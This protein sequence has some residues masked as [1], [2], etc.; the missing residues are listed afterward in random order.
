[1]H[2]S[3]RLRP[4]PFRPS[5]VL[6]LGR[7][8]PLRAALGSDGL[9]R[10]ADLAELDGVH[11]PVAPE[12]G[13]PVRGQTLPS[14]LELDF[15]PLDTSR[16]L[17]LALS[18]WIEFGTASTMIALSQTSDITVQWPALEARGG[19]G[20]WHP[21]DTTVGLLGGKRR[22]VTVELDGLLPR[23]ADRLRLSGTFELHYDR[24]ALFE[25][26]DDRLTTLTEVAPDSAELRWRG[27][28]ELEVRAPT[29]PR[30]PLYDVVS[31]TPPWPY[32]LEGWCTRYGDVMP[33][34]AAEDGM[35]VV[36]N[37]GDELLLTL[38]GA[39]LPPLAPGAVR[40]LMWRSVGYNKEA[41]P[42]NANRGGVWPLGPDISY[43]RTPDEDDAW[44]REWNTR[45]VP[46]DLFA[47][48]PGTR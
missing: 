14:S 10:T 8:V 46:A 2:S 13:A 25:R 4:P 27:F 26:L 48:P 38:P 6:T 15:G 28:S 21:V 20:A 30:L 35:L 9:D 3:D 31:Q 29:Q 5:E 45:W 47:S 7:R 18:G 44:R 43:G 42:N 39:D 23:G 40:T 36:L 12:V 34:M 24:V 17:V 37:S 19:D 33:L 16:P 1:V 32:I 41:D 22:T 11:A